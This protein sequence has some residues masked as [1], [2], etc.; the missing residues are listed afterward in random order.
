M[1]NNIALTVEEINKLAH[2]DIVT[3]PMVRNRFIQIYDTLW[4]AGTGK[5]AYER[6]STFF[7]RI[8]AGDDRLQKAT[9]F[10]VFTTFID[11][12]ISGLSLEPGTRALC[13]L[14]GRNHKIGETVDAKGNKK[15]VYEGRLT[16][17]VSGY[18]ELVMRARAGQIRYADNPVLV[19]EED[20][21]SFGD[22]DGRKT[23]SYTCCFPHKSNHIVACYLRITR[24][25]G[26]VDYSVMLEEDWKRLQDYS[27]NNNRRWNPETHQWECK[28][29]ELYTQNGGDI[30]PGFLMAKCVKHAFKT[31]PKVRIG[32]YTVMES[33]VTET[34]QHEINDFYGVTETPQQP[35]M[36]TDPNPAYGNQ[37]DYS[38]GVTVDPTTG[39][40]TEDDGTF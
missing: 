19:Y 26:S 7:N 17:T 36:P 4:G 5:P 32:N 3:D 13:Y 6:E 18:G 15:G 1:S 34:P 30:D 14:T 24:A 8:L 40:V 2:L 25:D 20:S 37:P 22:N 21:F 39:E 35:A 9:K 38:A 10:S 12:A 29:N 11:L 16:L 27:A 31:Y 23:V 33:E 28:P